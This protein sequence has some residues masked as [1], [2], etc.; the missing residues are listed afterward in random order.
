VV[1]KNLWKSIPVSHARFVP[2]AGKAH[3]PLFSAIFGW[4]RVQ[5]ASNW[6]WG[7]KSSTSRLAAEPVP[8]A[9][10]P[11]VGPS[12]GACAVLKLGSGLVSRR[13][14]LAPNFPCFQPAALIGAH[15]HGT[16]SAARMG[17][18]ACCGY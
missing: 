7:R 6:D 11:V 12:G 13:P 14:A 17:V 2:V 3:S 9:C 1:K 15:T 16:G 5:W 8:W 18:L 4:F 10:A